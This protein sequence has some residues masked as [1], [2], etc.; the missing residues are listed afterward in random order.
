MVQTNLFG[1][2]AYGS[3]GAKEGRKEGKRVGALVL[4]LCC[5]LHAACCLLFALISLESVSKRAE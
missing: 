1:C 3:S 5:W 4:V 2:A